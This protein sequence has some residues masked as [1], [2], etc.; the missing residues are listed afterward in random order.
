M[1]EPTP[2]AVRVI[3][4]IE[5]VEKPDP[6]IFRLALERAAC[7]RDAVYV[8]DN[9]EF[10]IVPTAALGMF[11]VLIDRRGRHPGHVGARVTDLGDLP[12]VLGA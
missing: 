6:R 12:E 10:D 3:S 11:P 5:G 4:G 8:G 2:F 7:A 1:L 9:P